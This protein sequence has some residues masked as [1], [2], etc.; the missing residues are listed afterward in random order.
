[1]Y[2]RPDSAVRLDVLVAQVLG[3][4]QELGGAAAQVLRLVCGEDDRLMG[5]GLL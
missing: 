4:G 1:M 5:D 2:S 3:G